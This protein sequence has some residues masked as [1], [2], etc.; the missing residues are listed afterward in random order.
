MA[1]EA[2]EKKK[3]LRI[4]DDLKQTLMIQKKKLNSSR[5]MEGST[6]EDEDPTSAGQR[7]VCVC[8]YIYIYVYMCVD[9]A[10]HTLSDMRHQS[11]LRPIPLYAAVRLL[12]ASELTKALPRQEGTILNKTGV[13]YLEIARIWP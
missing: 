7:Q 13:V 8:V 1:D 3:M 2:E 9:T 10:V 5:L 12:G 4:V 11:A 6:G